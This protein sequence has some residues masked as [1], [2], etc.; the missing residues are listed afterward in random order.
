MAKLV[1]DIETIGE[2]FDSADETTRELLTRWIKK[3]SRDDKEYQ[4]ALEDVKNGLGFSP[5]TGEIVVIGVFDQE[6]N[7]GVVYFQAPGE[8]LKEFSEDGIK[9]K[10][11]PE[12][13]M[14]QNFWQG[15]RNYEEFISFNGRAFDAPFLMVRSAVHK[16]KPTVNLMPYRYATSARYPD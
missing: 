5:L 4:A 1:F 2:D 3:E 6:K 11:M 12:K 15:A 14:L 13:E 7:S 10:P 16:I 8:N 9:F